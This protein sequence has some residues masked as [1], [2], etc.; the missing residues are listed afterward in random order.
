M[1]KSFKKSYI[2]LMSFLL[3]FVGV[4]SPVSA[5]ES[6]ETV[7][8]I[9]LGDSLAAGITPNKELGNSY[10]DLIGNQFIEEGIIDTFTKEF[11]FP[12]Y[13]SQDVLDNLENESLKEKLAEANLVTISAGANDLLQLV[14]I[15]TD[16][17]EISIDPAVVPPALASIRS[18]MSNIISKVNELS[19]EAEIYIMGYYFP[20]PH[21]S[22]EQ[23][24]QLIEL[25]KTLNETLESIVQNENAFFIPVF[26]SFGTDATH[27]IPNPLDVHPTEEGYQLM[28]DAFFEYYNSVEDTPPNAPEYVDVPEAHWAYEKI[29]TLANAGLL[30]GLPEGEFQPDRGVTRAEAAF[31]LA[32]AIPLTENIPA[33][34]G[35]TDISEDHPAYYAIAKLTEMGIFV[36][37]NTFNPDGTLTRSQMSKII[38]LLFQL[39]GGGTSS[40]IDISS[41]HWAADYIDALATNGIVGGYSDG[42]FKPNGDTTRAQLAVVVCNTLQALDQLP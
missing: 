13:T 17:R 8:Y 33:N 11:S 23:K 14:E 25:S 27:L 41:D 38:T 40:F 7:N 15:N 12:G 31:I 30:V 35:F 4:L 21:A 36:K 1:I 34:P 22:D 26:D 39:E 10:A 3:M 2:V 29:M 18:N 20:Y 9:A 6:Q 16:T 32:N 37:A 19:P 5:E 28:A 42:T 24:A